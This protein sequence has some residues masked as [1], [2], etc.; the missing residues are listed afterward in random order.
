MKSSR[1]LL[2]EKW[3]SCARTEVI[4]KPHHKLSLILSVITIKQLQTDFLSDQVCFSNRSPLWLRDDRIK[5]FSVQKLPVKISS[6]FF[7]LL[8]MIACQGCLSGRL[9]KRAQKF[10][11][12]GLYEIAAENYLRSFNANPKNID[13]ATGLRRAGQ[14]SLDLKASNVDKACA[15]GDDRATV[16]SFLDVM[17]YHK[18]IRKTGID[19]SVPGQARTCYEEAKPRFLA[20][21]YEEARLLLEEENFSR[22][23]SILSEIKQVDPDY[24]DLGQYMRIS[25]SEPLYREGINQLNNGSYR[26]AHMTFSNLINNYGPYKDANELRE[27]AL[28]NGMLTIAIADFH[29]KSSQEN[30]HDIIKTRIN[31]A[32]SNLNN[33]F[34]RVVDSKNTALFLEEQEKAALTGSRMQI[35]RLMAARALLTGSLL[36]FDVQE[37]RTQRTERR[38]YLKEVFETEDNVTREKSTRTVYHKVT[39]N[40]IR[41]EN[42]ASGSFQFQL[43]SAET[44]AVLVSGVAELKP[45]D[46]IHFAVFEGKHENLVPGHWEYRDRESPKDV[47]NKE[48]AAVRSLLNL[49]AAS[50]TIRTTAE[51]QNELI[52]GIAREVSQ[53]INNYNPEQ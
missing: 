48:P 18:K 7:L 31:A 25:K 30:T 37:G 5:T 11:D 1:R 50:N 29:N 38:A 42:Q 46:K 3:I 45:A 39:Y 44:G 21:S 47:I 17:A 33:P 6:V 13:A 53:A 51:L 12:A 19:L 36:E 10:E 52:N 28:S 15:S 40:E 32:V 8:V 43:S 24:R 16:Y 49:F 35:G 20:A 2:T 22:A 14:R 4:D 27:D 41:R 34:I 23:E 9:V 26:K